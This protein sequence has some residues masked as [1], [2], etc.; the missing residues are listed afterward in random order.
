MIL[1]TF[2]VPQESRGVIARL[3][4]PVQRGGL[5]LGEWGGQEVAVL[6]TGMG[7]VAAGE[8][9]RVVVKR[10]RPA[11]V[12]SSGFA[13]GLDPGLPTGALLA[14]SSFSTPS[15]LEGLPAEIAGVTFCSTA[16]PLDTPAAKSALYAQTGAAAV[17][18]ESAAIAAVCQAT[19]TPLLILRIVSDAAHEALP[20]PSAVAYDFARQRIRH[21]A[22]AGYLATHPRRIPLLT[23][24]LRRLPSLQ[25][26]LAAGLRAVL[27]KSPQP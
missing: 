15:L 22:I 3:R 7:G 11:W 19:G 14:A 1:L 24:F 23:R 8:A 26:D 12:L 17:D 5:M 10:V 2:A 16:Q 25:A 9:L 21:L 18:L 6:H 13:G 27:Q 4:Q 20:L